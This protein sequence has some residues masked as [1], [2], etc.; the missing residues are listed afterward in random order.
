MF[1]WVVS[2]LRASRG[3]PRLL[4][5][6]FWAVPR[7]FGESWGAIRQP[8]ASFMSA[9]A[10]QLGGLRR[11]FGALGCLMGALACHMAACGQVVGGLLGV[12]L[13]WN[14][15][16]VPRGVIWLPLASLMSALGC[17]I[18]GLRRSFGALGV[19]GCQ[20]KD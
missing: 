11:S 7:L 5:G 19:F 18:G 8:L 3:C 16:L 20:T 14:V 13:P 6:D 15:S 4:G 12:L 1:F 10:C 17:Q 2:A 9:L